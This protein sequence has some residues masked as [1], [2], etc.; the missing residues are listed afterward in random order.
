[1]SRRAWRSKSEEGSALTELAILA[2]VFLALIVGS[3]HLTDMVRAVLK[4][5]EAGRLYAW[6]FTAHPLSDF[7]A[8]NHGARFEAARAGASAVFQARYGPNAPV[9]LTL[10]T[11]WTETTL[12]EPGAQPGP[13]GLTAGYLLNAQGAVTLTHSPAQV[14]SRYLPIGMKM[15][16]SDERLLD[17]LLNPRLAPPGRHVLVADTWKV[18]RPGP[19]GPEL[20]G[21]DEHPT[22]LQVGRMIY[23]P[24]GDAENALNNLGTL[25]GAIFGATDVGGS[26]AAV[27]RAKV[28][29]LEYRGPEGLGTKTF[30]GNVDLDS[31]A[32]ETFHTL[33]YDLANQQALESRT[34]GYMG[35]DP[36]QEC[37][38]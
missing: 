11:P 27:R 13:G 31:A 12:A 35:C 23:Q 1:M 4:V 7:Q 8:T 38:Q 34:D 36:N 17:P 30:Q 33:P 21:Y 29:A 37:L 25:S 24:V 5:Q 16:T 20:P 10:A 6:E 14:R 28:R 19:L 3:F 9:G 2:P 32:N 18:H 22:T 15:P 26:I